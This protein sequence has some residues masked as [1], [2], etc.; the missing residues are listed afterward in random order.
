MSTMYTVNYKQRYEIYIMNEKGTL[1]SGLDKSEGS[2]HKR[3]PAALAAAAGRPLYAVS[4]TRSGS[5]RRGY[6]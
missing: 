5:S 1:W 4:T 2:N 3:Y 6:D